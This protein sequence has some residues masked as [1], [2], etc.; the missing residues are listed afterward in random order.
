MTLQEKPKDR[1]ADPLQ[2]RLD[3]APFKILL[4]KK[5]KN[6][7]LIRCGNMDKTLIRCKI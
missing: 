3:K 5:T 2:F 7:N 6:Y 4:P 1:S